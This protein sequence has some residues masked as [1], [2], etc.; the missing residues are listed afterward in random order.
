MSIATSGVLTTVA[1]V[2]LVAAFLAAI[3]VPLAAGSGKLRAGSLDPT[4]GKRGIVLKRDARGTAIALQTDGKIV[5]A[6]AGGLGFLLARYNPNG[7]LDRGFGDGGIV[8]TNLDSDP[9]AADEPFAVAVEPNGKIVVAGSSNYGAG[10]FALVR[11]RKNGSLDPS[12]GSG[13]KVVTTMGA[14]EATVYGL[15]L[16]RDGSSVAA[17]A[18]FSAV[19]MR[20]SSSS[21][22]FNT[23][24]VRS[25]SE[26][27]S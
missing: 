24:S 11:Y 18:G 16:R 20:I 17:G 3:T 14:G 27:W 2:V 12:F 5:V 1:R 7:S 9:R 10:K 22:T 4:F 15:V 26:S 6:G 13:G 25:S 23:V 19:M 8:T 21:V